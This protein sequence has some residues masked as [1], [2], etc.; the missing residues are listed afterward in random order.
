M[1]IQIK[2]VTRNQSKKIT[3]ILQPQILV[4]MQHPFFPSHPLCVQ[5]FY[6]SLRQGIHQHVLTI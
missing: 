4:N 6:L 1:Y 2:F 5:Y 3:F